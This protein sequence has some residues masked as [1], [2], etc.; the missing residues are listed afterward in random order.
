M[1]KRMVRL[2]DLIELIKAKTVH[3]KRL[4]KAMGMPR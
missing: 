3:H 1:R 2:F 4:F